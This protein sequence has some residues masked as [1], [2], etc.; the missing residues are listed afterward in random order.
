MTTD[1]LNAARAPYPAW[2]YPARA[3]WTFVQFSI[4]RV[5]WSRIYVLRPAILKLFGAKLPWRTLISGDVRIHFPWHLQIGR[6]CAIGPGV[7]IYNLGGLLIG[8]RVVISQDVYFCGGTHDHTK[9]NYPL[10]RRPLTIEDDVWIG[11][12]AFICPGVRVGK[13]AVVGAR[14]V[15]TKDV[16]P[17]KIVAGNPARVIRDRVIR[18]EDG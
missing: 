6:H 13:A 5:A 3:L 16:M 14:A 7:T 17:W 2:T 11:A 12:G 1:P 18:S 15:V 9:A 4:W 10:I 8:D